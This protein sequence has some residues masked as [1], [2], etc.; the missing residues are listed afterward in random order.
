V[1]ALKATNP[2][3]EV[4]HKA[5]SWRLRVIFGNAPREAATTF[6]AIP[7]CP[8]TTFTSDQWADNCRLRLGLPFLYHDRLK[9]SCPCGLTPNCLRHPTEN[10]YHLMACKKGGG[11]CA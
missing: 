10:G 9:P 5:A 11:H 3:D 7:A 4:A 6:Q 1:E 8:V 2:Q